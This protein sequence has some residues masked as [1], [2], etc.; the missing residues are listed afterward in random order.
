MVRVVSKYYGNEKYD[1][2]LRYTVLDVSHAPNMQYL[3]NITTKNE[4][5]ADNKE[6]NVPYGREIGIYRDG[7]L[8]KFTY[9]YTSSGITRL[10][11]NVLYFF[12]LT[13]NSPMLVINSENSINTMGISLFSDGSNV[14]IKYHGYLID[15]LGSFSTIFDGK[16]YN[17]KYISNLTLIKNNEDIASLYFSSEIF[18]STTK[19]YLYN[20]L[21]YYYDSYKVYGPV[22]TNFTSKYSPSQDVLHELYYGDTSY[23][24]KL[25]NAN[26][27]SNL[28][29]EAMESFLISKSDKVS[30]NIMSNYLSNSSNYMGAHKTVYEI[31]LISLTYQWLS[32]KLADEI[33]EKYNLEWYKNRYSL[34]VSYLGVNGVG[35]SVRDSILFGGLNS[36]ESMKGMQ[37]YSIKGSLL[38]EFVMSL[39]GL[40]STCAVSEVMK[41]LFNGESFYYYNSSEGMVLKLGDN[42]SE[43][44]F[45]SLGGMASLINPSELNDQY[46]ING[47]MTFGFDFGFDLGI[48]QSLEDLF[49]SIDS[50]TKDLSKMI[51]DTLYS[52]GVTRTI[53]DYATD[54]TLSVVGSAL[55][56]HGAEML[57]GVAVGIIIL[58][59]PITFPVAV[60][61]V[62]GTALVV[63]GIMMVA[64]ANDVFDDPSLQNIGFMAM[65][66]ASSGIG[67]K[68]V[69][70]GV[71]M[72]MTDGAKEVFEYIIVNPFTTAITDSSKEIIKYYS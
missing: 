39:T 36:F 40:D 20:Q 25:N 33:S 9:G 17:G 30:D 12:S 4:V 56:Y 37:D 21:G 5:T 3:V 35:I 24:D 1:F 22:Y 32:D 63:G 54:L 60:T 50:V 29:Y 65:D 61:I 13:D 14:L 58:G 64:Y 38:E 68:T 57:V 62:A 51:S 2:S 19:S 11:D 70:Y 53:V 52:N 23:Y 59:A 26:W 16:Y 15:D 71:K 44:V 42:S 43:L 47:G 10:S 45:Y 6:L 28:G 49:N 48:T 8:Y 18:T 55:F 72:G 41:G 34:T 46:N 67:S 27:N 7:N 31:F 69:K 66:L